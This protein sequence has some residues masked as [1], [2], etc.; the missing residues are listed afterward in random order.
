MRSKWAF[1]LP[2]SFKWAT[3]KERSIHHSKAVLV[4]VQLNG[5]TPSTIYRLSVRTKHP[6]AV[7]EKRPVERCVDFKTLPKSDKNNARSSH[8]PFAV[9]L[10]DAPKDVQ[11]EPGPQ[12]GTLLLSWRPN[13]SQVG[14]SLNS[15]FPPS[16][17][18]QNRLPVPASIAI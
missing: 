9:G 13:T 5:L 15:R 7:L 4:Q 16:N 6:R 8:I 3:N 18:S 10:P 2:E 12:P 1:A 11:V 17:H 14:Q